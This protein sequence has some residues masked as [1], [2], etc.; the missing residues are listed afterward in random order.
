MVATYKDGNSVAFKIS[1][2]SPR[3]FATILYR[4]LN[5]W[6]VSCDLAADGE[7]LVVYGGA[8][9]IGTLIAAF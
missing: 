3:A 9:P 4:I 6:G 7:E 5:H 1:D 8:N 2:G